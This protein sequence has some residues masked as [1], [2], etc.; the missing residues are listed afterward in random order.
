MAVSPL[1]IFKFVQRKLQLNK[2]IKMKKIVERYKL[3]FKQ[4]YFLLSIFLSFLF[5]AIS[6][7]LSYQAKI[8]IS[9]KVGFSVNDIL[10]DN[11]PVM[12]VDGILNVGTIF[13]GF[14]MIYF[15]LIEPKKIPFTLKSL[16]L[17]IFIRSIFISLTHIG[18][19]SSVLM[20]SPDD[21]MSRLLSGN[22]LFFSG[23][24]GVPFLAALVFWNEKIIRYVSLAISV[25]FAVCVL[26]GHFHYS[27]D[28]FAAFFI[29]YS[30][31]C[32]AKEI[33]K[34]DLKLFKQ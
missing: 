8:Y 19:P 3:I 22:D 15:L 2:F 26:L 25:I 29:T 24:T 23:H 14:F 7:L 32:I 33:F 20:L 31:F 9:S 13:F 27:I 5:L 34:K 16:A 30:I 10:L 4:R 21:M 11:L 1:I 18:P 17:F 12:D 6:L 28:V